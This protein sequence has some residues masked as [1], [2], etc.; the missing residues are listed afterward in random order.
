M[1]LQA[2]ND[3]VDIRDSEL[4]ATYTE[5]VHRR[6]WFSVDYLRFLKLA[7]L[8]LAMAIR[9]SHHDD[10]ASDAV[11]PH[12]SVNLFSH[13]ALGI[14]ENEARSEN[15]YCNSGF[16]VCLTDRVDG[17]TALISLS[18]TF[19]NSSVTAALHRF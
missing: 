19:S 9:N 17:A 11:E 2:S 16:N 14:N 3:V 8:K 7:Q 6:I 13:H 12:D 18:D 4:D 10:V 5:R 15:A 1:L